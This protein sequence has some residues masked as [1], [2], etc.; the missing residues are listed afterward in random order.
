M[1]GLTSRTISPS[2]VVS[3][4]STP[5]VAGWCGPMLIVR[6]SSCS[7]PIGAIVTERS[8]SRYGTSSASVIVP[9]RRRSVI[10]AREL[11]LVV[12]V[13]DRLAAH[14]EVAP[15]RIALVVLRHEDA[16]HVRMAVEHD[17]EHVEHL[18]LLEVRGG[19]DVDDG[20]HVRVV[21]SEPGADVEA[22]DALHRE[23]LV[24]NAEP[25]LGREVV[26]AVHA[27]EPLPRL[28][29]LVPE[30]AEHVADA[31]R[32]DV[33]R[34]ALPEED[35]VGDRVV[36]DVLADALGDQLEARGVQGLP[37]RGFQPRG[38]IAREASRLPKPVAFHATSSVPSAL[39]RWR[40]PM[41][42][43]PMISSCSFMIP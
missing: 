8:R 17:A 39:Y 7:S 31:L 29:V 23:Q 24:V 21:H 35:R 36:A 14:G 42:G 25:R 3:S 26:H 12:G 28:L 20:R 37:P 33:E 41:A 38:L 1:I 34:C 40:Q 6:S 9:G 15:L 5:W 18:A 4:R 22:V 10:P 16:A 43:S 13:D 11:R 27:H 30:V 2:S 32:R 19:V